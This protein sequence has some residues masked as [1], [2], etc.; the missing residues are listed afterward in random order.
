[1]HEYS[2]VS[3]LVDRVEVEVSKHPGAVARV[4]R[5]RV[6][7]LSGVEIELLRTAYDTFRRKTIC[8]SAALTID[9]VLACWQC[10]RCGV[11]IELPP[12]SCAD[13]KRPAKLVAGDEIILDRIELEVPDV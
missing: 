9:R 6:G 12:L 7:E 5:V 11:A 10:P 13:C 3:S 8:E 2:I 4:L 1:M